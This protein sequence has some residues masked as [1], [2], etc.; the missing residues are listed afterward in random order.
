MALVGDTN[1][2]L[3]AP[4]S[5]QLGGVAL[6]FER[7]DAASLSLSGS[8]VLSVDGAVYGRSASLE[9]NGTSSLGNRNGPLVVAEVRRAGNATLSVSR[10]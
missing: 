7:T 10:G 3:T 1:A 5:G 6:F 9:L 4:A 8:S 2:T